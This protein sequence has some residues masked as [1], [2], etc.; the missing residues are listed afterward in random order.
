MPETNC[1]TFD[2]N[3]GEISHGIQLDKH[4]GVHHVNTTEHNHMKK[5]VRACAQNPPKHFCPEKL[6]L[7]SGR[8]H[9]GH[10]TDSQKPHSHV[11]VHVHNSCR[12]KARKHSP[13]EVAIH[14]DRL[15]L[16][17]MYKGCGVDINNGESRWRVYVHDET[18]EVI[19]EKHA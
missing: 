13:Q 4:L 15:G 3:T 5:K 12:I 14:G 18:L 19:A 6:V 1:Y 7:H 9:N 2:A 10:I 17:Q 16:V 8:V 11:L